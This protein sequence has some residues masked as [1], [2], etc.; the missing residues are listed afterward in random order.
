MKC[1]NCG[2]EVSV[3]ETHCPYCGTLNPEGA[4]FH[5]EVHKRRTFNEFLRNEM[6]KQMQL[7]LL[8]RILN[9]CILIMALL[10]LLLFFLNM[11]WFLIKDGDL[12]R[13]WPPKDLDTRLETLYEEG[14]FGELYALMDTYRL[15]GEDYPYLPPGRRG[16]SSEHAD[17][18][19]L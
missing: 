6:K 19:D 2:G 17:G 13:P 9:L 1:P 7:P 11:G 8:Q 4:S 14:R 10:F 3:N 15:E 5:S 18:A 12:I 16:L